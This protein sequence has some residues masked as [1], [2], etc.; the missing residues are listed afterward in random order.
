MFGFRRAPVS[1]SA[2]RLEPLAATT[3]AGSLIY[4]IGDIHGRAD[5][6]TRLIAMLRTDS[7]E[8]C[9]GHRPILMFLGDYVDRGP[10][11][12]Q[13][14]DE[15]IKLRSDP[16]F[17]LFALCGNHD[18]FFLDF[19]ERPQLGA[20]WI[21][22]GGGATLASYGVIPPKATDDAGWVRAAEELMAA[23]PP[24]HLEFLRN[25][26]LYS[27]FGDYIFVHAG[28]R[29]EVAL[30]DQKMNDLTSIRAPFL[31]AADPA[32]GH[33]VVFGHTPFETPLVQPRKIGVDTGACVTGMLTA[34]A[35]QDGERRFLQTGTPDRIWDLPAP[36][37]EP[38]KGPRRL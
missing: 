16:W 9:D 17:K 24:S 27:T 38:E 3:P 34:L 19:L 2:P 22:Y 10:T 23:T 6:L 33:V 35:I 26:S 28:L 37:E 30:Q 11:S 32:P 29:P 31:D 8:R 1:A 13:V 14:L 4:V 7:A 12:R 15:L 25:T 20:T 18:Q 5:L 21:N 36:G